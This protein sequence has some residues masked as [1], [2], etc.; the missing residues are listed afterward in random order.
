MDGRL[1]D[2]FLRLAHLEF[3]AGGD[4]FAFGIFADD[5]EIDVLRLLA[6]ERRRNVR[7]EGGRPQA[8]ILVELLPHSHERHERNM[9]GHDFGIADGAQKDR[10]KRFQLVEKVFRY[11]GA[12]MFLRPLAAPWKVRDVNDEAVYD[13]FS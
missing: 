6:G 8:D 4:V 5:D 13:R 10:V 3:A 7:E 2:D 12:V 9:V 11:N 1:D